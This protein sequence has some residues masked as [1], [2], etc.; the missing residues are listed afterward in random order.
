[1]NGT[2]L[3]SLLDEFAV[4]NDVATS[5]PALVKM[6]NAKWL[7]SLIAAASARAEEGMSVHSL[8]EQHRELAKKLL[9]HLQCDPEDE[10]LQNTAMQVMIGPAAKEIRDRGTLQGDWVEAYADTIANL[11]A[12][13]RVT[14]NPSTASTSMGM[15]LANHHAELIGLTTEFGFLRDPTEVVQWAH[16]LIDERAHVMSKAIAP[17]DELGPAYQNQINVHR[18]LFT[19]A[20]RAEAQQWMRMLDEDHTAARLYPDGIPLSGVQSRFEEQSALL[21]QMVTE[22]HVR[23]SQPVVSR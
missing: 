4:G 3:P 17:H 23:Q 19:A 1:M 9:T 22:T 12:M 2:A 13:V 7:G 18:K 8:A 5:N 16:S 21:E 6:A 15:T 10:R 11:P 20:Y 14:S